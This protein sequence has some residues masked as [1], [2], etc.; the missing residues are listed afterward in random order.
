[1]LIYYYAVRKHRK[2]LNTFYNIFYNVF[3]HLLMLFDSLIMGNHKHAVDVFLEAEKILKTSD[4]EIY[5]NL[6]MY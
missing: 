2:Y 1:M 6:G 4:W 3:I 5:F